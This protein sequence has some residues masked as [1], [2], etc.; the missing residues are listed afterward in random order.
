DEVNGY[1]GI[2][3]TVSGDD[4]LLMHKIANKWN[5]AVAFIKNV[6]AVVYTSPQRNVPSFVSQRMRWTSKSRYY[7]DW[8][9]KLNLFIVYFFNVSILVSLVLSFF[10]PEL[11]MFFISQLGAKLI[12]DFVF[13]SQV[14]KFFNRRGLL[15]LF[16]PIEVI[17]ILYISVVGL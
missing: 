7:S 1:E 8:K 2:L 13:L 11:L 17:H 3:T 4:M 5:G 16:L 14:T 15:W 12:S 6:E 9:I 10:K